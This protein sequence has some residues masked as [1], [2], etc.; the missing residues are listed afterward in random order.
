MTAGP[1]A[2]PPAGRLTGSE[3][4]ALGTLVIGGPPLLIVFLTG[5]L[6][7]GLGGHTLHAGIGGLLTAATGWLHH[8]GGPRLAYPPATRAGLPGPAGMYTA[9]A[10]VSVLLIGAGAIGW[11]AWRRFRPI[12]T[13]FASAREIH[14]ELSAHSIRARA[15]YARPDLDARRAPLAD[16]G[17]H[18]G[19]DIRTGIDCYGSVEDS[20]LYLGPPRAGKGINLIIPQA[21]ACTGPLLLTG[22]RPD[23]LRA[24]LA[25]RRQRGPVAI[26]DPQHLVGRAERLR[27]SPVHG[28]RD[29]LIAISRARALVA[30]GAKLATLRDGEYWDAMSQAV[31]RCYLHAAALDHRPVREVLT[32]TARPA[33]ATPIRIL[34]QHTDAAPGWADELSAQSTAEP[35]QRDSVWSGVRRAFDCLADPRVLDACS[36][37]PGQAFDPHAFLRANGT[38]YLLGSPGSQLSV[39]P[40][41]TA[42]V[43]DLV[44]AARGAAATS[45]YGRL[46]PPLLLLLDEAANIAP[47]PSLPSLLAD[48]GGTGITTV[49]VLQS[50]AQSRARWGEP[51]TDALWDAATIKV[52]LGGLAHAPD[53]DAIS[54]LA[55]DIDEPVATHTQSPDGRSTSITLRRVP[56]LPVQRIRRLRKHR[57]I[58]LGR[59]AAPVEVDLRRA[60]PPQIAP[61]VAE[62][63]SSPVVGASIDET[64]GSHDARRQ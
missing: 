52:I 43:E 17:L 25:A 19:R 4:L 34:R 18:L 50:L 61:A 13:G 62:D 8:P 44:E 16:L 36:P 46:A 48:G 10:V 29:P 45:A 27:W 54:R 55:G 41:V 7:A 5:E 9:L 56:A 31:V 47:I 42:L 63:E 59:R 35:R 24:T 57:G 23:N 32:W 26:F 37:E 15:R 14:A 30:G 60:Q 39:A 6:A 20:Y 11:W 40:L 12:D 38:L 58:V 3:L 64:P 33:D 21:L 51:T 22:T 49:A 1:A 2:R 28:C 53:L